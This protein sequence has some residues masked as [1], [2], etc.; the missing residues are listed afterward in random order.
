VEHRRPIGVI[1]YSRPGHDTISIDHLAVDLD[2]AY[3]GEH[4]ALNAATC[5]V[6]RVVAIARVIK[7]VS[8][9]RLPYRDGCYLSVAHPHRVQE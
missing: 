7:G 2:Y 5:L 1:L 4:S 3:G 6:D 8:Q 9:V